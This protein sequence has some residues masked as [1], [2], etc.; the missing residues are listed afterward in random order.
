MNRC[1]IDRGRC[2]FRDPPARPG[3]LP[4]TFAGSFPSPHSKSPFSPFPL[5]QKRTGKLLPL[6]VEFVNPFAD[7]FWRIARSDC[8]ALSRR[9]LRGQKRYGIMA[10]A[11]PGGQVAFGASASTPSFCVWSSPPHPGPH[12]STPPVSGLLCPSDVV[13]RVGRKARCILDGARTR[14]GMECESGSKRKLSKGG[15]RK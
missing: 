5:R 14:D 10:A 1:L 6:F 3:G 12:F 4:E 9:P 2:S 15:L 7:A 8:G 13:V 11:R